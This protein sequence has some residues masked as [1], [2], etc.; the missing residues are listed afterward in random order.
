MDCSAIR[1]QQE[2]K[3]QQQIKMTNLLVGWG[4]RQPRFSW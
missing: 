3:N 1:K 2:K 4:N